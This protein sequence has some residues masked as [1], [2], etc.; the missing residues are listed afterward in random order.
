MNAVRLRH[1][2]LAIHV[3]VQDALRARELGDQ[4][5]AF[6]RRRILLLRRRRDVMRA[7]TDRV[8]AV[9]YG[10]RR[11]SNTPS[12]PLAEDDL[13]DLL[14]DL[15]DIYRWIGKHLRTQ[16]RVGPTIDGRGRTEL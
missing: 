11:P 16:Q 4:D 6:D 5:P 15:G 10:P 8:V 3:E 12:H 2:G 7:N 14:D 1:P 13:V 9:G